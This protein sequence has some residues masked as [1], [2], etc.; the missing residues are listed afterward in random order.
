MNDTNHVPAA[1]RAALDEA[2]RHDRVSTLILVGAAIIEAVLLG[3]VLAEV[4]FGNPTHKVMFLLAM[5][6]YFTLGLGIAAMAAKT[7]AQ[8]ARLMHA[9]QLMS[10]S[11]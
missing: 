10:E 9:I 4:D 7:S 5:L 1:V 11:R 2:E 3:F 8:N 6:T